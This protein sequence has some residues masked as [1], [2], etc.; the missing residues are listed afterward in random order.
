MVC[1]NKVK[2]NLKSRFFSKNDLI[3]TRTLSK[4]YS[5]STISYFVSWIDQD[6]HQLEQKLTI[7]KEVN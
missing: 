4:I 2:I 5:K 3:K 1:L 7:L 6:I